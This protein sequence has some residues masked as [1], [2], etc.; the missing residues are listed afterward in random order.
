MGEIHVQFESLQAGQQGI[1]N[2]YSKLTATLEQLESDLQPMINS[3]S[4]AAQE[5]YLVCKKQ[6]DDAS[7]A[8]SQ[9]LSS[10]GQAVGQAHDNYVAAENAARS[11]WA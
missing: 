7:L 2:N 11:N 9:V 10:V 5:A 4:G 8:L 6:W 3:W 1:Q